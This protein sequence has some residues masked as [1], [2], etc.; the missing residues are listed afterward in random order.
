MRSDIGES[1]NESIKPTPLR[2][3][4]KKYDPYANARNTGHDSTIIK[5]EDGL[6]GFKSG[7]FRNSLNAIGK[8]GNAYV[9]A[10]LR[11]SMDSNLKSGTSKLTGN[12]LS[13]NA[14]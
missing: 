1:I 5:S 4:T 8:P 7:D 9:E 14:L 11:E 10:G 2:A 13:N 3:E 6:K 12:N